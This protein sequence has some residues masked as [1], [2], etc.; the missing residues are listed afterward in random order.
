MNTDEYSEVENSF[1]INPQKTLDE[2]TQF[3]ESFRGTQQAER[4]RIASETR[5][6]G[7]DV[8]IGMGGLA[9]GNGVWQKR[10]VNPQVD[11]MV[12]D[13]R[14]GFQAQALA[15]TLKN[16]LAQA[17]ERYNQ[18]K[19]AYNKRNRNTGT[20]G[21]TT[22]K[23]DGDVDV[24]GY[25]PIGKLSDWNVNKSGVPGT[26]QLIVDGEVQLYNQDGTPYVSPEEKAE[27]EY[28]AKLEEAHRKISEAL[29]H[30]R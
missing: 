5:A 27:Q 12:Q 7:S 3:L 28:Q 18:A 8:P 22:A 2:G 30:G 20:P 4:D 17:K 15:D 16:E 9:G 23:K 1:Y 10:Y 29:H 25:T 11:K 19:R 26:M 21:S 14:T 13:L 6:L 24:T